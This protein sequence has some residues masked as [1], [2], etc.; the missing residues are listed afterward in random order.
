MNIEPK[1]NENQNNTEKAEE[2]STLL[3]NYLF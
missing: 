2:N 1:N 3:L